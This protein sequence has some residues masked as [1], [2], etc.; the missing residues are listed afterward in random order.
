[1]KEGFEPQPEIMV[2]VTVTVK[3]LDNQKVI[4]DRVY[5]EAERKSGLKIST[6]YGT[7]IE[8]PRAAIIADEMAQTAS[9]LLIRYK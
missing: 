4:C 8:I 1:M 6:L 9:I 3:E 2:P 7:M 5:A